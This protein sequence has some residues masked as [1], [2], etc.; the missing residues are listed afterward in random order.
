MMDNSNLNLM[1]LFSFTVKADSTEYGIKKA[2]PTVKKCE[3]FAQSLDILLR[4]DH[5]GAYDGSFLVR[6]TFNIKGPQNSVLLKVSALF[7]FAASIKLSLINQFFLAE[8]RL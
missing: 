2:L 6:E 4:S 3:E 1:F 8:Q 5:V 7:A